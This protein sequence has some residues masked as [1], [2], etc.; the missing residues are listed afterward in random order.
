MSKNNLPNNHLK[1][2]AQRNTKNNTLDKER[3]KRRKEE[4]EKKEKDKEEEEKY[5]KCKWQTI[6]TVFIHVTIYIIINYII[7]AS[8]IYFLSHYPASKINSDYPVNL[9]DSP[10]CFYSKNN[11]EHDNKILDE[12]NKEFAGKCGLWQMLLALLKS[13]YN[14]VMKVFGYVDSEVNEVVNE[15][16]ESLG[17]LAEIASAVGVEAGNTVSEVQILRIQL[18]KVLLTLVN[19]LQSIR[20]VLLLIMSRCPSN[21]KNN[22]SKVTNPK[23]ILN[24]NNIIVNVVWRR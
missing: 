3:R 24:L 19:I 6:F 1:Y 20:V 21:K 4:K 13:I 8:V 7:G 9:E 18:L 2:L 23:R 11:L 22:R 16:P 12:E 10:Y 15:L 14:I 17:A 5:A